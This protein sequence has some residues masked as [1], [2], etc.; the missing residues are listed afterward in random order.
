MTLLA[1]IKAMPASSKIK[2]D[3]LRMARCNEIPVDFMAANSYCSERVPK[4]M[5]EV[6]SMV[7]GRTSGI[8]LGVKN[9]KN[10]RIMARERSLPASSEMY[11]QMVWSTKMNIKMM[12]TLKKVLRKLVNI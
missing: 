10:F 12:K 1:N 3:R 7:S 5:S 4:T 9:H 2:T 8:N 6:T 11:S